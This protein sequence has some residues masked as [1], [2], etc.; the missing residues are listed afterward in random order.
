[1]VLEG[2]TRERA[3]E[4]V[5][6]FAERIAGKVARPQA[7]RATPVLPVHFILARYAQLYETRYGEP[8][9]APTGRE[10][11]LLGQLIRKYG[12]AT[13]TNRLNFLFQWD[14]EFLKDKTLN[15]ALLYAQWN[16]IA[17]ELASKQ[18]P[19]LAGIQPRIVIPPGCLHDPPCE[20]RT[21]HSRRYVEDMRRDATAARQQS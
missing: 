17:T 2:V 10:H 12:A 3:A 7:M 15:I 18:H 20:T 13:V 4:I 6:E 19:R 8:P 14:D 16:R 9:T 11:G 1:L 5:R 21:E